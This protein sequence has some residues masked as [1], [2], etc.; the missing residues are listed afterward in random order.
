V[1]PCHEIFKNEK[2]SQNYFKIALKLAH[3][4]IPKPGQFYQIRCSDSNDPLLRRPFS[5]H[6][7]VQHGTMHHLEILYRVVGKG[8]AWLSKRRRGEVL[9]ILGPF[10]N[11]FTME[12]EIEHFVLVARGIGIAPLYALAEEALK[13]NGRRKIFILTGARSRENPL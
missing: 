9:D 6:R 8:T 3:P 10:G 7:L 1:E 2:I 12:K 4:T 5:F 11:S 13:E